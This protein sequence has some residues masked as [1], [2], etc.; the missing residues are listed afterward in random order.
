MTH[1]DRH[2]TVVCL[3]RSPLFPLIIRRVFFANPTR[4]KNIDHVSMAYILRLQHLLHGDCVTKLLCSIG[5]GFQV[6][7]QR[8]E[9][10]LTHP[11]IFCGRERHCDNLKNSPK[12]SVRLLQFSNSFG[13][14]HFILLCLFSYKEM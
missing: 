3:Y 6:V 8:I 1:L 14:L 12:I 4:K 9:R 2:T 10:R 11:L 7:D 5:N 13:L